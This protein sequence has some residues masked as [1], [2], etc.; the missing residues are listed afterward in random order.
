MTAQGRKDNLIRQ[1]NSAGHLPA[2][3]QGWAKYTKMPQMHKCAK[4]SSFIKRRPKVLQAGVRSGSNSWNPRCRL[5]F[6][7]NSRISA[8]SLSEIEVN[9]RPMPGMTLIRRGPRRSNSRR[10]RRVLSVVSTAGSSRSAALR[11][12]NN[13]WFGVGLRRNPIQGPDLLGSSLKRL[14]SGWFRRCPR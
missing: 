3:R 4:R 13:R 1:K 10:S 14:R 8:R 6:L 12:K 11:R 9:L 2:C 7:M 5:N